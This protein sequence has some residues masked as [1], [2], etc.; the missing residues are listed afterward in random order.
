MLAPLKIILVK[1]LGGGPDFV[2]ECDGG[3]EL[4]GD[5]PRV[6]GGAG[7]TTDHRS[8]G[9]GNGRTHPIRGVHGVVAEVAIR[10]QVEDARVAVRVP[11]RRREQPEVKAGAKEGICAIGRTISS[12][13]A[14]RTSEGCFV[15]S[16]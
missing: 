4:P 16:N 3:G 12:G 15:G 2:R 14:T 9:E 13:R 6:G 1:N 8:R 10:D 11:A 7:A 5:S